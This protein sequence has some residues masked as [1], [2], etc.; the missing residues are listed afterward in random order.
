MKNMNVKERAKAGLILPT[1]FLQLGFE[2]VLK[3]LKICCAAL[4]AVTA[5]SS[6]ASFLSDVWWVPEE[7]GWGASVTQ[8][9]DASFITLFVYGPNGEPIW[10]VS[11]A[12]V[13]YPTEPA[14]GT[15]LTF[16]PLY[17]MRGPWFG[18]VFD[19]KSVQAT[20]VGRLSVEPIN[21]KDAIFRYNVDGT[22]VTK[23][24]TR[25]TAGE[26]SGFSSPISYR[27]SRHLV[28]S[29]N[30]TDGPGTFTL[31]IENGRATLVFRA[32]N[33]GSACTYTG[34]VAQF[35][36]F[37]NIKG[38]FQCSPGDGGE[39]EI[40]EMELNRNGFT[41]KMSLT[42]NIAGVAIPLNGTI[43]GARR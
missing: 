13:A 5:M 33:G 11:N 25:F 23:T 9:A 35:G 8:Q 30:V 29:A 37:T 31:G 18:G 22:T 43:A 24:A 38:T 40:S 1:S 7:S 32:D 6:H 28:S 19:P 39:V 15:P 16:G 27:G 12:S 34:L 17:R 41:A 26:L 36:K 20:L 10:Y 3:C 42:L 2:A 14:A 4:C 21:S